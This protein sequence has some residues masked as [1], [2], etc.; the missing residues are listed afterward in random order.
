MRRLI[1]K[2][3]LR[4]KGTASAIFAIAL[5]I[6]LVASI[7]SLLNNVAAQ[8]ASLTQLANISE[9]YLLVSK[10][11]QGL[12]DSHV[13]YAYVIQLQS[14]P[15]VAYAVAQQITP[16]ALTS[17][18]ANLSV[19]V[20]GVDDLEAFLKN[21]HAYINGSISQNPAETNIGV[22]C[23]KL[24]GVNLNGNLTVTV[25]DHA[26]TFKVVGVIQANKQVDTEIV[27]PLSS[28]QALTQN[29]GSVSFIELSLKN[30][31]AVSNL[32]RTLPADTKLLQTQ[33]TVTFAQD[34][35]NQTVFFITLWSIAIYVVVLAAAY[36]LTARLIHEAQCELGA[37]RGLG[38]QKP[39]IIS[40][41]FAYTLIVALVGAALGVALGV[42]G[43]QVAATGVR[44]VWGNMALA[45]FLEPLQ[46]AA[47]LL[48]ALAAAL[49]GSL[50]PIFNAA[51]SVVREVP[52]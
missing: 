20:R 7:F 23:S 46:A 8:T 27:M 43:A 14:N 33:Q 49:I 25:G 26:A 45:P 47:I 39:L 15:D 51:R 50:Y 5:L 17:E 22:I 10:T 29:G 9:T 2:M 16:A 37:L 36:V 6:A 41:L 38:A 52:L 12:F 21:N 31:A 35:N 34:I 24:A 4:K 42:V 48:P 13:D 11:S 30:N 3:L 44:W 32:T 40:L 18:F 28:L 19:D 1:L